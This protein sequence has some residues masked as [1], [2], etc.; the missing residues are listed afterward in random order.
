MHL[1]YGREMAAKDAKERPAADPIEALRKRMAAV[2]LPPAEGGT[3]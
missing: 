1:V 2:Q 3:K